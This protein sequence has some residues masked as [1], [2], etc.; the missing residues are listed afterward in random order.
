M[1]APTES[2][3]SGET[4]PQHSHHHGCCDNGHF[5]RTMAFWVLRGWLGVRALL[6]GIEKFSGFKTIQKPFV[7]PTTGMPDPS[8]ALVEVKEKFYALTNYSAI[9]Q[10]LKDKFAAEPLL[11]HALTSPFYTLL[12]P[13]LIALGLMLLLGIGTRI[14]LFLQGLLYIGLTMGLIL[15]KQDDGV[16]WLAIHIALVAIA[17]TLAKHNRLCILKKW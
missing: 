15:I 8:G 13:A 4:D 14:S 17:L 2:K 16:S 6:T 11:P 1:T 7:D 3:P 12:G 5:E 10:S 9:P